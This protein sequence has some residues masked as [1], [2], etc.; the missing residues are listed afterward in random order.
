MEIAQTENGRTYRNVQEWNGDGLG[1]VVKM[2]AEEK[3]V[4]EEEGEVNSILLKKRE[5]KKQKKT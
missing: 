4:R 2:K 1:I 3:I 5:R